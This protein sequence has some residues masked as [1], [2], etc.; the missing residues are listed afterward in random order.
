MNL[1]PVFEFGVVRTGELPASSGFQM[2]ADCLANPSHR[3]RAKRL[4][5][6][7]NEDGERVAVLGCGNLACHAME[8]AHPGE[9]DDMNRTANIA[10]ARLSLAMV[11]DGL[12]DVQV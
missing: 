2:V 11:L 8:A 7:N 9:L 3:C 10:Q 6:D 5:F 4:E 12:S 1:T